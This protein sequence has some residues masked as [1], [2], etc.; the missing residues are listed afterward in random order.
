MQTRFLHFADCHLGKWQ[1]NSRERFNDFARAFYA[2]IDTAIA[3]KVDFVLLAGDLFEKRSIDALTLNQAMR[4]LERLKS[5]NIPCIAVEGNHERAYVNEHIGWMSFLAVRDLIV[6]LDA[7]FESGEV[8]LSAYNNRKGSYFEPR[9]GVRVHGLRYCGA[10]TATA[11]ETYANAL[12]TLPT[13][14][15][16]YTIFMAHAGVEGVLPDQT[17]GLTHR[18]WAVLQ[19]HIN[20]LALGHVHKPFQFDHWIY[21]P[22]SPESCTVT[23]A[24]WEDRGYYLVEVDTAKPYAEG[25]PKHRATLH[26]NP[27]RTFHRFTIKTDLLTSPTELIEHCRQFLQRKANDLGV[28]HLAAQDQPVVELL[29]TG[30][31]PFERA[32]LDLELI[33][34]LVYETFNP[35]VAL[36]KNATRTAEFTIENSEGL[37]RPELERQILIGLLEHDARFRSKSEEWAKLA[38]AMKQLALNNANPQTIVTEL[39]N[40]LQAMSVNS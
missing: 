34:K 21:N 7:P 24:T 16:E 12:T 8:R 5:H 10:A 4:G 14:G 18:Q 38:I 20:Y 31:L 35:L 17:G 19:P 30:V 13:S 27:R 25:D 11:V 40:Y 15:I 32:A 33:E 6:L 29:L 22:G 28:Q 37:S 1:Y 2:I 36:V 23:E 9:P 3:E 26:A 39:A